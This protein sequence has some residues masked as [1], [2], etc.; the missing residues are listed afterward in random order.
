VTLLEP[1]RVAALPPPIP[2]E[3]VAE[4][5]TPVPVGEQFTMRVRMPPPRTKR[6]MVIGGASAAASLALVAVLVSR[7]S[8]SHDT[9]APPP[10]RSSAPIVATPPTKPVEVAPTPKPPPQEQAPVEPNYPS[11]IGDGPCKLEVTST[12]AGSMVALDDR[13]VGP[14]PIT[15]AGSCDRHKI[16]I[17]HPRY[18]AE[19][20]FVTTAADKP[21]TLDV[22]LVRPTH[23]LW[24]FTNPPGA[25]VY[26][27]GRSAG[28]SPTILQV[29]GFSGID[30]K[31]ELSGYAAVTKRI[32]SKIAEDKV[33]LNMTK[34]P[35]SRR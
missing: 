5:F 7:S 1:S 16:D 18:K 15:V 34:N 14:S 22:T 19:Q 11:V 6:W 28:T 27:A 10:P 33:Y 21:N 29:S 26:L 8:A 2:Q 12:P 20:R 31:V 3:I 4:R 35:P 9:P 13:V 32:Y 30:V 17:T 23:Q 25:T 24:V